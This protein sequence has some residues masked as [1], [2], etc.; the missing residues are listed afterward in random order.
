MVIEGK[1]MTKAERIERCVVSSPVPVSK[2]DI[3]D[4]L[5]DVSP[6]TVEATLAKLLKEEVI[7]KQGLGRSTK[8]IRKR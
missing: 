7:E 4:R 2:R 8:Y 1:K 3:C 6:T 5:P